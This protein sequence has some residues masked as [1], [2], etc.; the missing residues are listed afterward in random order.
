MNVFPFNCGLNIKSTIFNPKGDE[1][2]AVEADPEI[3]NF[4]AEHGLI[5]M[6]DMESCDLCGD[7]TVK[8]KYVG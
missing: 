6:G 8:S 2:M 1:E 3:I 7:S 5:Q 4:A